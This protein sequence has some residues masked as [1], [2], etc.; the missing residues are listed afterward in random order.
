MNIGVLVKASLDGNMIR[1]DPEGN[2]DVIVNMIG[3]Q[4]M[5]Q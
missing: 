4:S 5:K 1:A 3:M 2:I